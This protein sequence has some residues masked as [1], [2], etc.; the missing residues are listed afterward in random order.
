MLGQAL[1]VSCNELHSVVVVIPRG[2]YS[3]I[4]AR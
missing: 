2:G 1:L 4:W 3:H